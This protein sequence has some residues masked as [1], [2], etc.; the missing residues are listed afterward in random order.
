MSETMVEK[1]TSELVQSDDSAELTSTEIVAAENSHSTDEPVHHR[2]VIGELIRYVVSALI[3]AFGVWV[4]MGLAKLKEDPKDQ[5]AKQLVPRVSTVAAES[6]AGQLDLEV[7]GTVVPYREIR[8]AAEVS[9]NIIRKYPACEAGNFVTK[10][11]KLLEIDPEDYQL[12]LKTRKAELAQSKKMLDE[13][14]Q[15]LEGV[16]KN[17]ALAERD[18]EIAEAEFERNQRVRNALSSAEFDQSRRNRLNAE[19]ALTGQKNSFQ[20]IQAKIE[21]L[22]TAV[23]LSE[24]QLERAELNLAKSVIVAP[25]DG[26]IVAEDVQEGEFVNMGTQLLAFEDTSRSEVICNLAPRDLEWIRENSK[27][28][29]D[30]AKEFEKNKLLAVYYLPRTAVSIYEP[31]KQSVVWKGELER[32]DGI[33]RDSRTRTIPTRITIE[34][35]VVEVDN[36]AHAL[37]RG[38]YVKCRIE[39]EVSQADS[40]QEFIT[41]PSIAV[42]PGNYVWVVEDEKLRRVDIQIVDRGERKLDDQNQNYVV[43]RR[44]EGGLKAGDQIVS[45]PIPQPVEGMEVELE[46]DSASQVQDDQT[47]EANDRSS[48]EDVEAGAAGPKNENVEP[49]ENAKAN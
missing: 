26:I 20:L 30:V 14:A 43:I 12:Q 48:P 15:E 2:T 44:A 1:P 5:S 17:V 32:F 47:N 27:V 31:G 9:G 34:Q 36:K 8:V 19:S 35:P 23:Q 18:Y 33:G 39:V 29:P 37:V 25:D 49:A 16:K 22:K 3:L 46:S 45:S 40:E 10:G 41:I 42:R 28:D 24:A 11:T 13:A 6:F 21:R 4:C 7:S 38:M